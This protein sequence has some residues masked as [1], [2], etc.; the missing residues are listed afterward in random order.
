MIIR[1]INLNILIFILSGL[2]FFSCKQKNGNENNSSIN[3]PDKQ[4]IA[5]PPQSPKD[6]AAIEKLVKDYYDALRSQNYKKAASFYEKGAFDST[7][8]S[9]E[10][11]LEAACKI[12][13]VPDSVKVEALRINGE[14]ATGEIAIDRKG[15]GG[16]YYTMQDDKGKI[17]GTWATTLHFIKQKGEW[18]ISQKDNQ[19]IKGMDS[20]QKEALEMIK[21]LQKKK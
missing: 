11:A 6:K 19:T 3:L 14:Q 2:C 13:G 4:T 18:K 21:Q 10:T 8:F 16:S 20:V 12:T 7:G 5:I 15:I 17:L 1:N 9:P